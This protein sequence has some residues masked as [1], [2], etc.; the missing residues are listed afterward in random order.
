[1]AFGESDHLN[2]DQALVGSA[3]ACSTNVEHS[4]IKPGKD[5]GLSLVFWNTVHSFDTLRLKQ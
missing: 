5:S 4:S 1:M 2:F 3:K